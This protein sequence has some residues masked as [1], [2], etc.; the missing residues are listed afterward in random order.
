M[1]PHA[2][3]G[4]DGKILIFSV[5]NSNVPSQINSRKYDMKQNYMKEKK[6]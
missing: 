1:H 2:M 4:V 6:V 5:C 3:T